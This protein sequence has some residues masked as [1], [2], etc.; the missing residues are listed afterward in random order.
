LLGKER[1]RKKR[2]KRV[3]AMMQESTSPTKCPHK[4]RNSW[5]TKRRLLD[6]NDSDERNSKIQ[7]QV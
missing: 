2:A 3:S 5:N 4:D 1:M 6:T 7:T